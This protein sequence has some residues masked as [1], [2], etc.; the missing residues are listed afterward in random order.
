MSQE[1]RLTGSEKNVQVIVQAVHSQITY[2]TKHQKY[3]IQRR[4]MSAGTSKACNMF[5]CP[6]RCV[7]PSRYL[8]MR[9]PNTS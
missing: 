3:K 5:I 7:F 9:G 1:V 4:N 8:R 6:H 2:T